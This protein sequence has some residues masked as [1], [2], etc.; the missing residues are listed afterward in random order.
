MWDYE[1][2]GSKHSPH[3]N[4]SKFLDK[5][6]FYLLLSLLKFELCH[7]FE[8]FISSLYIMILLYIPVIKYDHTLGFSMFFFMLLP[9]KLIS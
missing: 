5:C 3:F 1:L 9:K 8:G 4:S 7:S 2:N 6:N